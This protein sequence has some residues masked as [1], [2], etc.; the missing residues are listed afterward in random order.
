MP[1]KMKV[2]DVG[3]QH[4]MK[5][6]VSVTIL[7][8]IPSGTTIRVEKYHGNEAASMAK[9]A[10]ECKLGSPDGDAPKA[11]AP[12]KAEKPAKQEKKAEKQPEPEAAPKE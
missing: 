10:V 5:G 2:S 6:G 8:H 3:V 12:A 11:A 9:L 1:E 7:T 4:V